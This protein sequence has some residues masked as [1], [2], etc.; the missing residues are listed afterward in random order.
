MTMT[1]DGGDGDGDGARGRGRGVKLAQRAFVFRAGRL[2]PPARS[3]G[4]TASACLDFLICDQRSW[5]SD[6]NNGVCVRVAVA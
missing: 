6:A 1:D 3:G 5:R 2:W 4:F